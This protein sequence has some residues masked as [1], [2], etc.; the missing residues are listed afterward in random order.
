[1]LPYL[2]EIGSFKLPTYGVMIATAYLV[3]AWYLIKKSSIVG[4][5]KQFISDLI[6]YIVIFGFIG[7]KLLYYITFF[8]YFGDSFSSR[9][10]GMFSIDNLRAGFVFYGGFI[11]GA[12]T[13][14]IYSKKKKINFWKLA[15]FIAPVIPLA[16]AIGRLGCFSAGCCHGKPT[17]SIFGVRFTKPYCDVDPSLIGVPIH[18]TQLYES[19]GNFIIF[20]FLNYLYSHKKI[21]KEGGILLLYFMSYSVLRFIVEFF[22]GDERGN[23]YFGLSQAQ[24]I[25]LV[26][27]II[28][29]LIFLKRQNEK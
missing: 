6:F 20:L 26:I 10:A 2:I 27:I 1:M 14:Y 19:L 28:S 3:S 23:F 7:A 9:L 18:P 17:S 21:K 22:R 5:D 11:G 4:F 16:H 24:L 29:G 25:S 8:S 13:V 15:D 12:A